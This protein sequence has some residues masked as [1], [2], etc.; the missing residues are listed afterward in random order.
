[1]AENTKNWVEISRRYRTY[2]RLEKRL[3]DNTV[4]SYM[5]DL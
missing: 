2:I 4:E 3:A 1:M 5:R